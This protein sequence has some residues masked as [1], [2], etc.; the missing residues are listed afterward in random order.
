MKDYIGVIMAMVIAVISIIAGLSYAGSHEGE[1]KFTLVITGVVILLGSLAYLSAKKVMLGKVQFTSQR[2]ITEVMLLIF[3]GMAIALQNDLLQKIEQDPFPN[4]VVPLWILL[5]YLVVALRK[6][7]AFIAEEGEHVNQ[8]FKVQNIVGLILLV[9]GCVIAYAVSQITH[10]NIA[11]TLGGATALALIS[12]L[13][14]MLVISGV[15]LRKNV[16]ALLVLGLMWT[17]AVSIK[18][19]ELMQEAEADNK[20]VAETL[21]TFD[22]MQ[23]GEA[24][25]SS[26]EDE[27]VAAMQKYMSK[28]Q[29]IS[30]DLDNKINDSGILYTLQPSV[31]ADRNSTLSYKRKLKQL[32]EDINTAETDAFNNMASYEE[33]LKTMKHAGAQQAYNGYLENKAAGT[34]LAKSFYEVKRNIVKTII[35]LQDFMLRTQGKF[36]IQGDQILFTT[37]SDVGHYNSLLEKIQA[38]SV[39]EEKII[40]TIQGKAQEKIDTI[41]NR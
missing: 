32:L 1:Q 40:A 8:N 7:Q 14:V 13:V 31:L 20:L 5:A 41:K 34:R 15:G 23:G 17:G 4:V 2:R 22:K 16:S 9:T 10:F 6:R 27:L 25:E 3:A 30:M 37:D 39:E 38:L 28:A 35:E 29:A 26:S 18:S 24:I 19:Y 21:A 36:E 11:Y 33:Q 12:A